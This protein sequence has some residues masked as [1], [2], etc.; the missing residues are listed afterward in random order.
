MQNVYDLIGFYNFI[1][2]QEQNKPSDDYKLLLAAAI[3]RD[4][5]MYRCKNDKFVNFKFNDA[6]SRKDSSFDGL[7]YTNNRVV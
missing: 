7:Y 5:F 1:F 4:P 2:S 6:Q 3:N